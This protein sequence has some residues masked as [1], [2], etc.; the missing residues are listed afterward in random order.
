ML[1]EKISDKSKKVGMKVQF[2]DHDGCYLLQGIR[3]RVAPGNGPGSIDDEFERGVTTPLAS[4]KDRKMC[5]D[6]ASRMD[7]RKFINSLP[8]AK[9]V[10]RS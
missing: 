8:V 3:V 4:E 9:L 10:P 2:I 7:M 1:K 6:L 5:S